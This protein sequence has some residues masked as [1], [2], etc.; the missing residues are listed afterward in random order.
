[1]HQAISR[2]LDTLQTEKGFSPNTVVA[3]KNDLQQL[4]AYL[5]AHAAGPAAPPING[6]AAVTTPVVQGYLLSLQDRRY[7]Q[8]TIARKIASIKSFFH[9]LHSEELIAVNP[10]DGF[11]SPGIR[12]PLPKTISTLEV[13]EL[14]GQP[15]KRDKPEA[16]RDW[17]ML[18]L[19]YATGM[20]VTELVRL[21]VED[22]VMDGAHTYVR[23]IGRSSRQ[24]DIQVLPAAI[25]PLQE[26]LAGA[27]EHLIR[28]PETTALFV[29]RRG[30]RLTRQ[31]F[32]LILKSYV[33]S[34][35]LRGEITPHMLR[36]TSATHMLQ[37]GKLNL[38]Q[39]Q[40]FLGHASI[41]TTQV[42]TQMPEVAAAEGRRSGG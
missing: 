28:N 38:R 33:K 8:T 10:A 12:R 11:A 31:G 20:R 23:C 34:G 6:W 25:E 1:M 41:T 3:Y 7:A 32:W 37:S 18:C 13:D 30:E 17:A 22:V 40:E 16:K 27:R 2:F 29:N 5:E 21:N 26:Y 42:Y 19:L 36:H 35:N 39:L 24:R 9:F 15:L 14:L 4:L